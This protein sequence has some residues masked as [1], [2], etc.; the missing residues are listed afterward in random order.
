MTKPT[1]REA[2]AELDA[3]ENI[4]ASLRKAVQSLIDALPNDPESREEMLGRVNRETWLATGGATGTKAWIA[5]AAAVEAK[6]K[7][8]EVTAQWLVEHWALHSQVL[9][10]EINRYV[11]GEDV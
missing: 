7:P 3:V 11:R 10:T 9:A 4:P 1:K 6:C 8:R 2:Q 5:A